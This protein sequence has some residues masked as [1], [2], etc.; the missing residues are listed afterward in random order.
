[1]KIYIYT[2]LCVI[3][4]NFGCKDSSSQVVAESGQ[5]DPQISALT[6][7]IDKNPEKPSLLFDRA[8]RYYEL[9]NYDLAI[10]DLKKAI[11]L[12]TLNPIY[13]HLLSDVYLDNYNSK[14]AINTML[15]AVAMHPDRIP[16][17]LKLAEL[18][19]IIEDYDESILTINEII[20]LDPLN[21]EAFFMLGVNFKALNDIPRA[22]N[23]FQRAVELDTKM[24]D[25]WITLGE[26]YESKNDPIAMKYFDSAV[27]S[28][29][30]SLQALHAKAYYLQNHHK[31][32][33]ALA[34]YKDI[35]LKDR[36]YTDAY[37]NSGVLY[38]EMDSL[39][40][41]KESFDLMAKVAPT[42]YMGFFMLGVVYEKLGQKDIA[43]QNYQSAYH[44]NGEDKK[45]KEALDRLQQQ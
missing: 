31:V 29:P 26:I 7:E 27:L 10:L 1:M 14:E 38:M 23:A 25:A 39:Q 4:L 45:V 35:I 28:D 16:S 18:R 3:S 8:S 22:T 17:L 11:H 33:E 21:A 9:Q 36:N 15:Y 19:Y 12:D 43:L 42:N 44:L 41:A 5:M 30:E 40:K 6:E 37:L 2:L 24:T 32:P 13:Y 20:K 34:I